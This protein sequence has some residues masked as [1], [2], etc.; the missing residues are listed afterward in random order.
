MKIKRPVMTSQE[1]TPETPVS[2]ALPNPSPKPDST[3]RKQAV[4]G[5]PSFPELP[6]I[7]DIPDIPNPSQAR[8]VFE[9]YSEAMDLFRENM[10]EAFDSWS[11]A[12]DEWFE[13]VEDSIEEEEDEEAEEDS[14]FPARWLYKLLMVA[15]ILSVLSPLLQGLF[16]TLKEFLPLLTN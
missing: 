15:L 7:P 11:E 6:D 4:S 10:Q 5:F 1:K 3:I 14:P 8:E 9:N 16:K 13:S 12:L 2:E